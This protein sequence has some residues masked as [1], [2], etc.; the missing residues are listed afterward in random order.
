MEA[1]TYEIE[2]ALKEMGDLE[3]DE[4]DRLFWLIIMI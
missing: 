3:Q 1:T 4:Y 2:D